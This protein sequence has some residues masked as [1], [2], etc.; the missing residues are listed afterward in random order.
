MHVRRGARSRFSPPSIP[1]V[2]SRIT[3]NARRDSVLLALQ[4]LGVNRSVSRGASPVAA[5]HTCSA[6][7]MKDVTGVELP[8]S[9]TC[10]TGTRGAG[11]FRKCRSAR[12]EVGVADTSSRVGDEDVGG[13]YAGVIHQD[14]VASRKTVESARRVG[15]RTIR[16]SPLM[17]SCRVVRERSHRIVDIAPARPGTGRRT[18][19]VD[20]ESAPDHEPADLLLWASRQRGSD[21]YR[22]MSSVCKGQPAPVRAVPW[23]RRK[24]RRVAE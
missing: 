5:L 20:G 4:S 1:G 16:G 10:R 9:A 6:C 8:C 14:S 13:R 12:G 24:S 17:S 2:V 21:L 18:V 23:R 11:C 3:E 22:E 19:E 7:P 15:D